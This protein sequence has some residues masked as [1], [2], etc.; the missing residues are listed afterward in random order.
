MQRLL[1]SLQGTRRS[2]I[3]LVRYM[4]KFQ[5]DPEAL[6]SKLEIFHDSI[7]SQLPGAQRKPNQIQKNDQKASES[8]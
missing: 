1:G 3:A 8:C 6:G 7:V 5:H 2:A 4:L